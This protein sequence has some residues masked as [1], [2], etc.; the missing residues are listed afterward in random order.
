[1]GYTHY[2]EN[3]RAF[4][5]SEWKALTA[6]V[7]EL[8]A[9]SDVPIG[10]PDGKIGTKPKFCKDYIGFNG[11]GDD[12]HET[13]SVIKDARNFEFCKTARKPYDKVVVEFYKL[14]RKYDPNVKL[15]SDGGDEVFSEIK[16]KINNKWTYFAGNHDVKVGD[17]VILP[18]TPYFDGNWEGVVTAIGSSYNGPCKTIVGIINADDDNEANEQLS[19]EQ[20]IADY[21]FENVSLNEKFCAEISSDIVKIV[22]EHLT[23]K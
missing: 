10:G 19:L 7:K 8:L 9:N 17:R 18:P 6:E 3:K 4:T 23:K 22:C 14:I 13:A 1:M 11:I 2:I 12:S 21:L 5:D 15:S 20:K 16:I